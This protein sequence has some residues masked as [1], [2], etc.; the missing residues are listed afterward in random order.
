MQILELAQDVKQALQVYI[1][2]QGL[3]LQMPCLSRELLAINT[4]L[5]CHLQL[6]AHNHVHGHLWFMML[7]ESIVVAEAAMLIKCCQK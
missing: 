6:S 3:K 1:L 2:K 5:M 7:A 4:H